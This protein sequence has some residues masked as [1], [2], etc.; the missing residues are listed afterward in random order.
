MAFELHIARAI[1]YPVIAIVYLFLFLQ[2]ATDLAYLKGVNTPADEKEA[3]KFISRT[4]L[5]KSILSI[6]VF[7][8]FNYISSIKH[9]LKIL[10]EAPVVLVTIALLTYCNVDLFRWVPRSR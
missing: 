6:I 9:D 10:W 1:E 7:L 2:A 3:L 4:S 8:G 5:T